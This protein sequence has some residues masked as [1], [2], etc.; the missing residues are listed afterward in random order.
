MTDTSW[1]IP[2]I[3]GKDQDGGD[4]IGVNNFEFTIIVHLNGK[5]AELTPEEF[6]REAWTNGFDTFCSICNEHFDLATELPVRLLGLGQHVSVTDPLKQDMP[7]LHVRNYHLKCLGAS[8]IRYLPVSHPW[9]SSVAEAY[10]LCTFNAKASQTCYEVPIRTL[11]AVQRRFGPGY[12]LWHD[13]LSIPQWQD[14][15]R[16]T[17]ILP[18]I[19]KIFEASGCS[20]LHLE[21]HP[22]SEIV[23]TPT[24]EMIGRHNAGLQQFFTAHL[25][26][27]LWPI[28]EFDRAGEAYIMSD[29][30]HILEPK[31]TTFV[32]KILD[33]KMIG[34]SNT[35]TGN[36]ATLQW[37][38]H[39]PL[40]IRERQEKKCFGYTFDMIA[41]LGCRSFRDKFI[42]A[43]EL[44]GVPEYPQELPV[45]VPDA[46]L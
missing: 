16:G 19:F 34:D 18:Q 4:I 8:N 17:A 27:R 37:I 40:F 21:Q 14:D 20:I 41:N 3:H 42:G 11:M 22:P 32:N 33:A 25:F 31:F 12:M 15:L 2:Y 35:P 7:P 9:H 44:L 38:A 28:V 43:S 23:S 6:L 13:Y 24:L 1:D 46:C 26:T 36:D 5:R 29:E 10:A 30:Y 45:D 39:L